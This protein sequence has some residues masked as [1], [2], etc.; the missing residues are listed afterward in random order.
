MA[1]MNHHSYFSRIIIVPIKVWWLLHMNIASTSHLP[2]SR[3]VKFILKEE[4]FSLIP[5]VGSRTPA[6]EGVNR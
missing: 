4:S 3:M 6:R 1:K 2:N 5:L